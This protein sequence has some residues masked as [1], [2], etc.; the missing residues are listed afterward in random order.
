MEFKIQDFIS[1]LKDPRRGQ[2]QRHKFEHIIIITLMA[3]LSG[4]QGL[5]GIARFA[6]SNAEELS[7]VLI[8]ETWNS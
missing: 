3:I 6:L 8:Y 5:K 7:T 2:G 1:Q 4:H